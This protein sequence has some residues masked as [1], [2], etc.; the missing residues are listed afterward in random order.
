MNRAERRKQGIK[1][2]PP[3]MK[4]ISEEAYNNAINHAYRKGYNKA[5]EDASN[6]AV[7]YMFAVPL[8]V[9]NNDFNEIRLKEFKGKSRIEHFFEL[10]EKTYFQYNKESGDN[11]LTR[12]CKDLE[13]KTGFDI[14]KRVFDDGN[15][16]DSTEK[17]I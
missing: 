9:L 6:V 7:F 4:H 14:A 3:K 1:V 13:D 2:P 8:L 17:T 16:D 12:M 5:F 15:G 11:A 10:C